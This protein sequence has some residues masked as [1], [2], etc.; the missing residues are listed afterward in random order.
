MANRKYG[1]VYVST[2]QKKDSKE[3]YWSKVGTAFQ[4]DKS[5]DIAVCLNVL[6]MPKVQTDGYP[7]VWLKVMRLEQSP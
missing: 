1:D 7:A 4:D 6:P 2:G 5:G 3:K